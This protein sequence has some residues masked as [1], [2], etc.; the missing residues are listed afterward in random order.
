MPKLTDKMKERFLNLLKKTGNISKSVE[1][2]GI[3]RTAVYIRKKEDSEFS[4]KWDNAIETY[5]DTLEAEADRRAK[6]GT[7]RPVFYQGEQCGEV[8][9]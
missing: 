5:I 6:E 3:S 7:L 9:D 8:R 4:A 1:A 2:I